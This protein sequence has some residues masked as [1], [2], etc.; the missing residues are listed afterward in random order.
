MQVRDCLRRNRE[1][2][3]HSIN[4]WEA[5]LI[6]VELLKRLFRAEVQRP[7]SEASSAYGWWK[8]AVPVFACGA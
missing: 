6:A 3:R 2:R 4:S 1:R 5:A 8:R 7:A